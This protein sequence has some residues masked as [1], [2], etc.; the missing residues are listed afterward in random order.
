MMRG[1]LTSIRFKLLLLALLAVVPALGLTLYVGL[2]HRRMVGVQAQQE[3]LRLV[4]IVS[5]DYE[6]LIE[7]AS[8]QLLVALTHLPAA[9]FSLP[10]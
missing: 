4:R 6:R 2:E 1:L 9:R 10:C 3:A 7:G 8:R 5:S